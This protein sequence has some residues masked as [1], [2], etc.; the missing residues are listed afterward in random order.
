METYC[1]ILLSVSEDLVGSH[2]PP[3]TS[4]RGL[5]SI[6]G[7]GGKQPLLT[8][9]CVYIDTLWDLWTWVCLESTTRFL[10]CTYTVQYESLLHH[11]ESECSR[12][13]YGMRGVEWTRVSDGLMA[14]GL[15][16]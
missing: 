15:G 11:N 3:S 10:K 14:Y 1:R 6:C 9:W 12:V 16:K 5:H 8:R 13:A 4:P 7:D 2:R